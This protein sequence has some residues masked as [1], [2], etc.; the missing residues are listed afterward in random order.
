MALYKKY[1]NK[2]RMSRAWL[3]IAVSQNNYDY[4][5]RNGQHYD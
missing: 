2:N 4:L 5:L 1:Q 3:G